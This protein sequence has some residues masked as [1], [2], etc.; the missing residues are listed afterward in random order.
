MPLGCMDVSTTRR[1]LLV[2]AST[3][4]ADADDGTPAFV[5]DL[6]I[7][8]AAEFDTVVLVPSVPGGQAQERLGPLLV[9]RFRYFPR[10]WENLADGAI[11]ENLRARPSRWLQVAPFVLAEAFAL[12]RALRQH[13]PEVLHLHWMIPQGIAA[14]LVAR[15]VPWVVTTLGGDVYALRDPLSRQL[16]RT[17]LRRAHSVT[18]MNQDMRDRLLQLGAPRERTLVLPMGFDLIGLDRAAAPHSRIPGRILVVGRLVEKKGVGVLID[19]VRELPT[20]VPWSLDIVGDGPL[21]RTLEQRAEGLPVRFLGQLTRA[22]LFAVYPR[23]SVV[24]VPSVPA[25]SG[26]QDGLPVALLEA[27][28]AGAAVIGS[29]LPGVNEVIV[30][31]GSGLLVP[32]GDPRALTAALAQVL[33]DDQLRQ[34]LG[35]AAREAAG[36]FS[37]AAVGERYRTALHEAAGSVGYAQPLMGTTRQPQLAYS[38]LQNEMTDERSR[39]QKVRKILS[40]IEHFRGTADLSGRIVVDIGC[41]LGWF[42]EAANRHGATAV[43][44]DIDVPGL[45]R[46]ARDRDPGPAFL[47]ADGQRLPMSTAS[48][49]IVVFNHI[50]EHVL[51]PDAVLAEIRRVLKPDGLVYLGMC[52]RLT[53]IEPHYKL[54]FLSWLPRRLANRYIAATGKAGHYHEQFR[55]L[56]GLRRLAGGL[57]VHDYTFA[58]LASPDRFAAADVVPGRAPAVFAKFGR[59]LRRAVRPLA[60][61]YIWVGSKSPTSPRGPRLPVP[62]DALTM[63]SPPRL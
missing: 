2:V 1:R 50:Y 54:P 51:D 26:D 40:V 30:D 21:R 7:E 35:A 20:T 38:E 55:L 45:A 46:A 36:G 44:V 31:G 39:R 49:D 53:V 11:L 14:L 42:V 12:R 9:R 23:T 18:T 5:R 10:R 43:G 34:R 25:A 41:S 19:A 4:P 29:D 16:K 62:P 22:E 52:N 56:P 8:A 60:P 28:S 58:I 3:F 37:S 32:P 13:R 17:I 6:A 59:R 57:H 48:V 33:C 63:T 61:T 27:M 15:K 47:C 24:V